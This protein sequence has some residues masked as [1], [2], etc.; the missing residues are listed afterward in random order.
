MPPL[1]QDIHV[2]TLPQADTSNPDASTQQDRWWDL[3][4]TEEI[5]RASR[6]HF[7]HHAA[8][9]VANRARLRVL[10]GAYIDRDP[11]ALVIRYSETGKPQL[12]AAYGDLSFNLSHTDGL[13]LVAIARHGQLGVDIEKLSPANDSLDLARSYFSARELQDLAAYPDARERQAAFYRCWTRKEAFL[14]ALGDGLSR[15]L[16]AFTVSADPDRAAL[17][18]CDWD[19]EGP[20]RWQLFSIQVDSAFD[21]TYTAALAYEGT[22]LRLQQPVK[23]FPW[24]HCL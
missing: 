10:L 7:A 1:D 15:P 18:A 17:L 14:K 9:F 24:S 16:S 20:A 4:S 19:P 11:G 13:A 2:W 23:L 8:D 12:S 6:F 3:L 5:E 22:P 21:L